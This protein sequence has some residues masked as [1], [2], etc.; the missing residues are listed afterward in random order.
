[1]SVPCRLTLSAPSYRALLLVGFVVLSSCTYSSS[2]GSDFGAP[3]AS[4][5][6][7]DQSPATTETTSL[8]LPTTST[9]VVATTTTLRPKSCVGQDFSVNYPES[10]SV[11]GPEGQEDDCIWLSR[12]SLTATTS[13]EFVPEIF[14]EAAR[15][16]GD[17]LQAVTDFDENDTVLSDS[18]ATNF[19]SFPSTVFD[20]VAG[21]GSDDPEDSRSRIIVI[22]LGGRALV[23]TM[24]EATTGTPGDYEQT[25]VI[26]NQVLNSLI[27]IG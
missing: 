5:P 12:G 7:A 6:F 10:W 4:I 2:S 13:D 16:Y 11:G 24:T 9:S 19:N 14:F 25:K 15:H 3:P 8:P 26:L 21:P 27:P 18:Y 20:V 23:A 22:D 1:M 17:A